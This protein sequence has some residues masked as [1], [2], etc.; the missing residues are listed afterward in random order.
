MALYLGKDL[1]SGGGGGGSSAAIIDVDA[2]PTE[3][4]NANV[5]YR[6]RENAYTIVDGETNTLITA[7]GKMTTVVDVVDA[8]PEQ[9]T[10]FINPTDL[11]MTGYLLKSDLKLYGYV[12][13]YASSI[14][15]VTQGWHEVTEI[16]PNNTYIVTSSPD[17]AT[18]TGI[19]YVIY[20]E[21]G[22][23]TYN[24]GKWEAVGSGSNSGGSGDLYQ[25]I[26]AIQGT[27]EHSSGTTETLYTNLTLYTGSSTPLTPSTFL[28]LYR[29]YDVIC[30]GGML[31]RDEVGSAPI[32]SP[33][34]SVSKTTNLMGNAGL[35]FQAGTMDWKC[36]TYT[37][38]ADNFTLTDK[39]TKVGAGAGGGSSGG[40]KLYEHKIALLGTE[41]VAAGNANIELNLFGIRYRTTNNQITVEEAMPAVEMVDEFSALE[42]IQVYSGV[43]NITNAT[44]GDLVSTFVPTQILSF[45]SEGVAIVMVAVLT[46]NGTEFYQ[47]QRDN[48]GIIDNV[49]EV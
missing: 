48:L 22:L 24:N 11:I 37:I 23:F 19:M 46:E 29:D 34:F 39:V 36:S 16:F 40:E 32:Y 21:G 20:T 13:S 27:K 31:E 14:L 9:P 6:V 17:E 30:S 12:D 49:K 7:L 41:N 33:I 35:L 43:L 4:I 38:I 25:H 42:A 45:S 10:V 26:I 15:L 5:F 18:E 3:N 44:T 47:F 2:L 1:I 8:L 28:E